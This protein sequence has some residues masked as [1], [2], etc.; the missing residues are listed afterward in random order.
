[1]PLVRENKTKAEEKE[2]TH[3][4]SFPVPICISPTQFKLQLGSEHNG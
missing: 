2:E 4:D 1:M 3:A